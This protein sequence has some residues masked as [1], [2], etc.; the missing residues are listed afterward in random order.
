[1]PLL[2]ILFWSF[3]L[4]YLFR[5]VFNFLLPVARATRQVRQQF[6]NMQDPNMRDPMGNMRNPMGDHAEP[7]QRAYTTGSKAPDAGPRPS[8][9]SSGKAPAGDYIDFEEIK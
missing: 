7:S 5:F 8:Q 4:Y 1:M 6:R 3:V 2:E 9:T